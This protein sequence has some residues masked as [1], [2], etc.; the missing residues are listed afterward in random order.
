MRNN[1]E[2]VRSFY[3]PEIVASLIFHDIMPFTFLFVELLCVVHP[4]SELISVNQGTIR[5][6]TIL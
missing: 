3:E 6:I 1:E 5:L 2:S 4:L